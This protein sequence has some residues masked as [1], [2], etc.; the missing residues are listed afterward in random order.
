VNR[1]PLSIYC[2][3]LL[4]GASVVIFCSS[5]GTNSSSNSQGRLPDSAL[6]RRAVETSLGKWHDSPDLPTTS[7]PSPSVVFVDQQR[8][9][10]QRLLAFAVLGES[11]IEGC[12]RFLVKL[13]LAEPDESILVA[14]YVFG[15][16]PIWVYRREDLDMIMHCEHPMPAD[17][18]KPGDTPKTRPEQHG[19]DHKTAA[20]G[21][22]TG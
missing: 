21:E 22:K 17:P 5:C 2:R 19:R 20:I 1:S 3:A 4:C 14:Y 10:G 11:E 18:P 8:R 16:D 6:A 9:P 13:S 15:Q 7:K 12:R